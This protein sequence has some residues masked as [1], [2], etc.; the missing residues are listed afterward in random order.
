MTYEEVAT[1]V[2]AI[3][4]DKFNIPPDKFSWEKPLETLQA[5]FKILGYLLFLEQLLHHKFGQK[6][7]LLENV[8]TTFHTPKDVVHL[9]INE[10]K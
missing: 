9:I 8:S 6:I 7:P 1:A 3:L 10:L 5:D 4:L 2:E